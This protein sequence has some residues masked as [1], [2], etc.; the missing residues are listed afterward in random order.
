MGR[1]YDGDINGKFWFALQSSAVGERFGC[2][3]RDSSYV[4]Y[5]TEDLKACQNEIKAIEDKLGEWKEFYDKFFEE[6]NGWNDERI[7][8]ASTKAGLDPNKARDML[9]EY[10]DLGFGKELEECLVRQGY[11][12][13][14]AEF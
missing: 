3:E 5:Y 8:E 10:A 12:D 11:C 13:F 2:S 1:Y 7:I 9:A 6:N 14:S 4:S